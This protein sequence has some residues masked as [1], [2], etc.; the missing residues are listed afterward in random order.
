MKSS[1][2]FSIIILGIVLG[3]SHAQKDIP[4]PLC[5]SSGTSSETVFTSVEPAINV[6]FL[7]PI[8]TIAQAVEIQNSEEESAENQVSPL[9]QNRL[10][11]IDFEMN[12]RIQWWIKRYTGPERKYFRQ[13]L[14]FF[15]TV[16]PAMEKIFESHAI[17]R[18]LVYLCMVESGGRA[19]AVSRSGAT[20]YWQF[21]ADT[22]KNYKLT[23]N[24][25][26]DERR[27]LVK[28]TNAAARYLKKL[29]SIFNDWL[30]AGAAYNVGEGNLYRIMKA[31]PEIDTFWDISYR[32]PIKHETLD[33]IP[34]LI[35]TIVLA[36]NRAYYG[37]DESNDEKHS[38]LAY[39]TVRV[40][41]MTYLDDIAELLGVPNKQIALL[42]ADLVRQCTPPSESGHDLKVPKGTAEKVSS[43]VEEI[44]SR[45]KDKPVPSSEPDQP[46]QPE[47]DSPST[48]TVKKGD[49][50]YRIAKNNSLSVEALRE[51]NSLKEGQDIVIGQ[52]LAIPKDM[53]KEKKDTPLKKRTHVVAKGEMLK[54]ISRQYGISIE[55]IMEANGIKSK[56]DIHPKMVLDIPP[57]KPS[58]PSPREIQYKVKKGDTVWSIS[59]QFEVS[60][61]DVMKWNKLKP[62][63]QIHPG[64][65]ITIRSR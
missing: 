61:Y 29:Y 48:Y 13:T 46:D 17:P 9:E 28:S 36:K 20:G 42:N 10:H 16:R 39:E 21:T 18:D 3:C 50:L 49:T 58:K 51:A 22:A 54:D 55:D 14:V 27:D 19:N 41:S 5:Y 7:T 35:A 38:S 44:R 2:Y 63:E 6:N 59:R 15:D 34:K 1:L 4:P 31:H 65:K 30:L 60:P 37:I 11:D 33:Y 64:D 12:S 52:I 43:Y 56:K 53:T 40:P 45:K 47:A 24:S 25:W 32:M 26:V 23:V 62:A 8:I 57:K